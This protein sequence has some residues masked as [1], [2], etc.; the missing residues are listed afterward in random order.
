MALRIILKPDE[1][2]I[3]GKNVIQN[4]PRKA[5][6]TVMNDAVV[7]REKDVLTQEMANTP[8]KR[9]YFVVQLMYL[10]GTFD[11]TKR[12]HESYFQLIRDFSNACP[13]HAVSLCIAEMGEYIMAEDFYKALKECKKLIEYETEIF[14]SIGYQPGVM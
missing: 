8:A 1:K 11:E 3:I 10:A 7:L 6:F 2:I 13:N 4:G 12:Y 5:E 9:I 14:E